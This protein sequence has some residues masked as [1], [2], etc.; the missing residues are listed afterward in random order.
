MI[1]RLRRG[2]T[3]AAPNEMVVLVDFEDA[4]DEV[5]VWVYLFF[6]DFGL[7]LVFLF[8]VKIYGAF[9]RCKNFFQLF[10]L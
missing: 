2:L 6:V 7:H 4:L 5:R 1:R 9:E 8:L 3:F 10:L